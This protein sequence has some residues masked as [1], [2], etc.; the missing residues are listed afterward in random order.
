LP[1]SEDPSIR[2]LDETEAP[3]L[4]EYA[5]G[6]RFEALFTVA[7]ALGLRKGEILGLR[8]ID[9]DLDEGHVRVVRALH[10]IKGELPAGWERLTPIL[11]LGPLKTKRSQRELELRPFAVA[12]LRAHRARQLE[13]ARSWPRLEGV[14][15]DFCVVARDSDRAAQPDTELEGVAQEG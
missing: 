1:A 2:P 5:K 3:K 10:A 15:L 14:R 6:H 4:L 13:E 9:V 12:A 11:A 7:V 8:W